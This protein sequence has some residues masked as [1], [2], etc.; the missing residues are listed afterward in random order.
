MQITLKNLHPAT[1]P[2]ISEGGGGCLSFPLP[3]SLFLAKAT[4]QLQK[5]VAV[6][7]T[8]SIIKFY[9]F[10]PILQ[11]VTKHWG[12]KAEQETQCI[13]Q[14]HPTI[15][16]GQLLCAQHCPGCH[17]TQCEEV[18]QGPGPPGIY[19]SSQR[20]DTRQLGAGGREVGAYMGSN[21]LCYLCF[22]SVFQNNISE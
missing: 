19:R 16:S 1:T 2:G 3:L 6:D 11:P 5:E 15:L 13:R 18:T 12:H 21:S 8:I 22:S 4:N 9:V 20:Y 10:G 17:G 14:I 7:K